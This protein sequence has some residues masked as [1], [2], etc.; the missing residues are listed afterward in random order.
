[1]GR[2]RINWKRNWPLIS[3]GTMTAFGTA[4]LV[5]AAWHWLSEDY[6][7]IT[8]RFWNIKLGWWMVSALGA[9]LIA[10]ALLFFCTNKV[11]WLNTLQKCVVLALLGHL[12]LA[13]LVQ[14]AIIWEHTDEKEREPPKIKLPPPA[15]GGLGKAI[16][17]Q[18]SD[19]AIQDPT[20]LRTK[21]AEQLAAKQP[22][23]EDVKPKVPRTEPESVPLEVQRPELQPTPP[24]AKAER[25]PPKMMIQAPPLSNPPKQKPIA[26]REKQPTPPEPPGAESKPSQAQTITPR[27]RK[28][29][30]ETHPTKARTESLARPAELS[31][32][33]AA[34]E[35]PVALEPQVTEEKQPLARPIA[36]PTETLAEPEDQPPE[37]RVMP[38]ES[39]LAREGPPKS[40]PREVVLRLN[41]P[42]PTDIPLTAAATILPQAPETTEASLA[43]LPPIT[44]EHIAAT[45][46]DTAGQPIRRGERR[47][48]APTSGGPRPAEKLGETAPHEPHPRGVR[49]TTAPTKASLESLASTSGTQQAPMPAGERVSTNVSPTLEGQIAPRPAGVG[50][51][52]GPAWE[53][54]PIGPPSPFVA[55]RLGEL[56]PPAAG[57]EDI[58]VRADPAQVGAESL[59]LPALIPARQP[60]AGPPEP[61]RSNIPSPGEPLEAVPAGPMRVPIAGS[62]QR[63]IGPEAQRAPAGFRL[64]AATPLPTKT[65]KLLARPGPARPEGRSLAELARPPRAVGLTAEDLSGVTRKTAGWQQLEIE[66]FSHGPPLSEGEARVVVPDTSP[67]GL[68]ET[69]LAE[70]TSP[71][72]MLR[73]LPLAA[74]PTEQPPV[75]AAMPAAARPAHEAPETPATTVEPVLYERLLATG[76]TIGSTQ[77]ASKQAETAVIATS[78]GPDSRA[79]LEKRETARP[80]GPAADIGPPAPPTRYEQRPTLVLAAKTPAR[81]WMPQAKEAPQPKLDLMES[82]SDARPGQIGPALA[83]RTAEH[84][85]ERQA[86]RESPAARKL[87]FKPASAGKPEAFEPAGMARPA[88]A[89]TSSSAVKLAAAGKP[90]TAEELAPSPASARQPYLMPL[91][92]A[93]PEGLVEPEWLFQRSREKRPAV[94]KDMGG[95]AQSEQAV[96]TALE[97][98]ARSQEPDGRWTYFTAAPKPGHNSRHSRDTALT[99]LAALCFLAAGHTP[100]EP[101]PYQQHTAKA[102]DF[103]ISV[104]KADGD[105][106]AGGDMYGHAMAALAVTEAAVMTGDARHR[107]AAIKAARFIIDAQDGETGGWRYKPGQ[108]GDTS[109]LGW[110]V[111][112]LYSA[113]HLGAKLPEK[114]VEGALRW[115]DGVSKRS[116][117]NILSGYVDS[118]PTP[119]MT[120]EAVFSRILLGQKLSEAQQKEVG[121]YLLAY[122]P[123]KGK[124][125]LWG[126]DDFY[127]MYYAALALMQ[128]QNE[129]WEKWNA[130]MREHLIK[131]Q[132]KEGK[133]KGSWDPKTKY[134]NQGGRVY[135]TAMATLTLEVYYRYLPIYARPQS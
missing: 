2:K 61:F 113:T 7:R 131:I 134:S 96:A 31:E 36:A 35:A 40:A 88:K 38:K 119:A 121:E 87:T 118:N 60:S 94:I 17:R 132:R 68:G 73:I 109:V 12:V 111:M 41:R 63:P 99:G 100:A 120:A 85:P 80:V 101:G 5:A 62:E 64:A 49:L 79:V 27:P 130:K 81:H 70:A 16:R 76:P 117:N 13:S 20:L 75:S 57:T 39:R 22:P 98:L 71:A 89:A 6:P 18:I 114:T 54:E 55:S 107:N 26:K 127:L 83:A 78:A 74:R 43:S 128:M 52:P 67:A 58:P 66:V 123:G 65:K 90:E 110:Q 86:R 8:D 45:P 56:A 124:N 33:I 34:A 30:T 97:F 53:R 135:N 115:L 84:L 102:M 19:L 21:Q 72:G 103:L 28:S 116:P 4:V 133:L 82:F 10:A 37:L 92:P 69:R 46:E 44:A 23:A 24:T 14:L 3:S 47:L 48:A 29:E 95:S 1:V 125:D 93:P 42:E 108:A 104:Q 77:A 15:I 122:E 112:V 25:G 105:L 59:T 91:R 106:R 11:G 126:R 50:D 51:W 9:I 32:T 129:A